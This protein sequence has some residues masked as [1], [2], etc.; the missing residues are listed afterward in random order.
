MTISWFNQGVLHIEITGQR[1]V[2]YP[3]LANAQVALKDEP[4]ADQILQAIDHHYQQGYEASASIEEELSG[5]VFGGEGDPLLQ[6]DVLMSVVEE[7][8]RHRHGV[9]VA[10]ATFGLISESD[11]ES[12]A[13]GLVA[14]GV[15]VLQVFLP[16]GNPP[17]YAKLLQVEAACFSRLCQFIEICVAANLRVTCFTHAD[18]QAL[19]GECRALAL[20]LGAVSFEV[21]ELA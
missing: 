10:V 14:A 16:A 3:L 5:I 17:A 19:A 2:Q 21:R 12:I 1:P 11:M 4:S 6:P 15:E 18:L 7:F 13:A 20:A 8:K 9:P